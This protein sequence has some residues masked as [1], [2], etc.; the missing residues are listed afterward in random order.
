[1]T[2]NNLNHD[3]KMRIVVEKMRLKR[4]N[5][6][7]EEK[8]FYQ[9]ITSG[10]QWVTFKIIVVFCSLMLI[11]T[12]IDV[13][14]D[15]PTKKI[16]PNAWEY[17]RNWEYTWHRVLNV[18]DCMFTPT[19]ADW[20]DRIENSLTMTYSPIFQTPKKL[21]FQ[22]KNY[23]NIIK[24][25]V[26]IRQMSIFNWFPFYQIILLIPFLTY[27][28]RRQS[29]WFNFARIASMIIVF[30]GTLMIIFFSLIG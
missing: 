22:V 12:T 5:E 26:E 15:G 7:R 17:N 9:R 4:E 3:E 24:Q 21:N 28:F 2:R 19:L 11:I 14:F 30:P 8:E 29:A 1:M 13:F 18:E 6:A 27:I 23:E 20:S 16:A 25:Q 10:W